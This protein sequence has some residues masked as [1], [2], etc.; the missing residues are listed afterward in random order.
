[1]RVLSAGFVGRYEQRM[2]NI[3]PALLPAFPGRD[4]HSRALAAGVKLHGCTVHFVTENVDDG[5]IIGQAALPVLPDDTPESLE[6][7]VLALEHVLYPHCLA[8]VALGGGFTSQSHN[9]L[10]HAHI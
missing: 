6:T 2:V 3:H 1:M 9:A 5:P 8:R 10:F 7:R 4:T